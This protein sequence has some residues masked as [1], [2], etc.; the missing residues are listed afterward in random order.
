VAIEEQRDGYTLSDDRARLQLDV[1]HGFMTRSY[2]AA[3]IDR[4][5]VARS[6]EHTHCFGL[7]D[8]EGGQ[9]GGARVLTDYATF[10]Y[11]MDVFVL[12][13]YRGRGLSVWLME[14]IVAHPELRDVPRWRLATKDAHGLY[15][16]VGFRP[17]AQPERLMERMDPNWPR[18]LPT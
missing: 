14:T 6:L 16:K 13:E 10:A 15:E 18:G 4:A 7:Y 1:I 9:V 3:G 2:C 8:V 12:E 17:L 5:T 11:V